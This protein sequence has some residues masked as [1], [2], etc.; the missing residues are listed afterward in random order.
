MCFIFVLM[1]LVHKMKILIRI[2]TET[3]LVT[4]LWRDAQADG[5][6]T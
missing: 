2:Y 3:A 6:K 1:I 4:H 5:F